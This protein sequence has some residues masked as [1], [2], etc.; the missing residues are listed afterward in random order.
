[1]FAFEINSEFDMGFRIAK[2]REN[3]IK[4][5]FFL[6]MDFNFAVRKRFKRRASKLKVFSFFDAI[7]STLDLAIEHQDRI[8]FYLLR[9]A[10][11]HTPMDTV[12]IVFSSFSIL[13]PSS[14]LIHS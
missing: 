14:C 1:M 11:A 6:N 2:I 12:D 8:H 3:A 5:P 4:N 10:V 9:S 13:M 7:G